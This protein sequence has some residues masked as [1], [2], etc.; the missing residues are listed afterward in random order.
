MLVLP[1][2]LMGAANDDVFFIGTLKGE[3]NT[4]SD[5]TPVNDGEKYALVWTTNGVEFAG[6]N[7]DGTLVDTNSSRIVAFIP[8]KNGRLRLT[9]VQIAKGA[10][11]SGTYSLSLLDTRVKNIHT[12][13]YE[14]ND[15]D[16]S[17]V[18]EYFVLASG[19]EYKDQF[20]RMPLVQF[21]SVERY[22]S[23]GYVEPETIISPNP[24]NGQGNSCTHTND[25]YASDGVILGTY[26]NEVTI[27]N[28]KYVELTNFVTQTIWHDA[29]RY[30]DMTNYF[31]VTNNIVMTNVVDLTNTIV[32]TMNTTNVI[33]VTRYVDVTNVIDKIVWHDINRYFDSTNYFSVTN[34]VV[35][36]NSVD[37][38]NMVVD[39][40][41]ST[42]V[43]NV[44]RYVD[45][46]NIIDQTVWHDVT[47]YFD[48]TNYFCITNEFVMTNSVDLTN[49]VVNTIN[50]TNAIDVTKYVY[51]TNT[52]YDTKYVVNEVEKPVY[53]YITITN[54]YDGIFGKS[55]KP[56]QTAITGKKSSYVSLVIYRN[57]EVGTATIQVGKPNAYGLVKVSVKMKIGKK[58]YTDTLY[59]M[60][61][62]EGCVIAYGKDKND[63]LIFNGKNLEGTVEY[64]GIIY[65]IDGMF[66]Q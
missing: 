18:R 2:L 19:Y 65:D 22:V 66:N 41:N 31:Y 42:N 6:F 60:I 62:N 49:M 25:M 17:N 50:E 9:M 51:I 48:V 35:L 64:K 33:D 16:I 59:G 56:I 38:T 4:Y 28:E 20:E 27:T 12:G 57:S 30:T 14:F 11:G 1:L 34:F 40:V 61:D 52:V 3:L 13:E 8:A 45:V 29:T 10:F 44:T 21:D 53:K 46:T 24:Q 58:T 15:G 37:L 63:K 54:Y 36:T 39:I 5:S 7:Y 32:N 47:R 43:I 26:T 55:K 23:N